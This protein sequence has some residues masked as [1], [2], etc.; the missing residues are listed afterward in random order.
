MFYQTQTAFRPPKGPKNAV[1][2][3]G[4]LYL[5]PLILTFKL[6]QADQT[7]LFVILAQIRS[8]VPEIFHTQTKNIDWRLQKQNLP[9]FTAFGNKRE[10][11][12]R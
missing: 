1:F 2:I 11:V 7:C 8:A 6:V 12:L 4:D 3:P 10:F 5:W 9:Q